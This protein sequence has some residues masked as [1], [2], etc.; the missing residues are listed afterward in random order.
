[1][2]RHPSRTVRTGGLLPCALAFLAG[3][4]GRPAPT[5]TAPPAPA[6]LSTA[7]FPEA[8]RGRWTGLLEVQRGART[9]QTADMT[10]EILPLDSAGCYTWRLTYAQVGPQDVRPYVVC[11][12]DTLGEHWRID[13]RNGI[14]LDAYVL[15][16]AL[17]SRFEVMSNLLLTRDE[18][19]GDTLFHEIVSG[20]AAAAPT[21]DTVLP[22]GDTIPPVGSYGLSSRQVARLVRA[23][24]AP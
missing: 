5:S 20:G 18:L 7:V 12:A 23:S 1:M 14:V 24:D 22:Q 15:G 11:P 13:E 3:A 10:L 19:R 9:L 21:G 2:A 8:W 16:G 4:C 17:Y 6:N